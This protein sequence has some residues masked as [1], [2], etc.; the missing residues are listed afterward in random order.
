MSNS[1]D[2]RLNLFICFSLL[3]SAFEEQMAFQRALKEYVGGLDPSYAKENE[4]LFVGFEGSF[5]NRHVTPRTLMSRFLGN[6]VCVEGI[7]TKCKLIVLYG[8]DLK[9]MDGFNI[10]DTHLI[11]LVFILFGDTYM[12]AYPKVS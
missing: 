7:V 3:N 4:E 11:G 12:R 5:G 2:K 6:L 9:F 8:I 10:A 1:G